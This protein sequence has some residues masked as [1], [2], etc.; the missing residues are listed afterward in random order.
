MEI[1]YILDLIG[2]FAFA[3]SGA[4]VASNKEFDLFGV[5]IIAFVT[6]VG[7]GMLRDVLINAHPINW[8]GDLNYIWVILIA[9]IFTFLFK[10]KISPLS[11]TMFLFD[12]IGIGGVTV[13]GLQK[14][15]NF[16]L[17]ST[18]S[19]E[20]VLRKIASHQQ[21][22]RHKQIQILRLPTP[23]HMKLQ[24]QRPRHNISQHQF[25]CYYLHSRGQICRNPIPPYSQAF[26]PPPLLVRPSIGH[27]GKSSC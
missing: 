24:L 4:I 8:I 19:P 18:L 1:V 16:D 7:G 3:I 20:L 25:A 11:K 2:T 6:A 12:T 14:G 22:L 27:F 23:Q 26:K 10:S 5:G 17:P 21:R 9:V 13:L 15:L